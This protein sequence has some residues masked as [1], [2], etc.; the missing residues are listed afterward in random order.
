M[1]EGIHRELIFIDESGYNLWT[2]RTR[3]R[4]LRGEPAIRVVSG[5]RGQN[6]TVSFAVSQERGL[7]AQDLFSG[8]M[9]NER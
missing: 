6:F 5:R 4:S 8:G 1:G 3:G 2:A 7:I 9:T